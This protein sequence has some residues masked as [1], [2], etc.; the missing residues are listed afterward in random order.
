MRF[1]ICMHFV[2]PSVRPGCLPSLGR[3]LLSHTSPAAPAA[4]RQVCRSDSAKLACQVLGVLFQGVGQEAGACPG[5]FAEGDGLIRFEHD[6]WPYTLPRTSA[7]L[8]QL[9]VCHGDV[10]PVR[11]GY[12]KSTGAHASVLMMAVK[13]S[14]LPLGKTMCFPSQLA[15]EQY[16]QQSHAASLD[17]CQPLRWL[18]AS[19]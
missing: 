6:C 12:L 1:C 10:D 19:A 9:A 3:H 8:P 4:R 13:N 17:L 18:T 5:C 7:V 15:L 11:I 2:H 14:N 16:T